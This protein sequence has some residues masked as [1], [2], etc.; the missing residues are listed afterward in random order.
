MKFLF[1]A[2]LLFSWGVNAQPGKIDSSLI[3]KPLFHFQQ[4][5]TFDT[6]VDPQSWQKQK[7][8]LNVSFA[9]TDESP[10]RTEVPA[11]TGAQTFE[12]TGWKGERINTMILA[13]SPDTIEQVRFI[14]SD[15]KTVDGKILT[16]NNLQLN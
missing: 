5:Y 13:W 6:P 1:V 12:G 2:S 4:E 16:K 14:I 11:M 15:L 10:F 7:P 3:A 8:G 9:S